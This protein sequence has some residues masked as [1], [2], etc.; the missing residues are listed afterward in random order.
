LVGRHRRPRGRPAPREIRTGPSLYD[1]ACPL[2]FGRV[3]LP[4]SRRSRL[5]ERIFVAC[6]T[7]I[8]KN[9]EQSARKLGPS[10]FGRPPVVRIAEKPAAIPMPSILD[11]S[12]HR[13][14]SFVADQTAVAHNDNGVLLA[15]PVQRDDLM[16]VRADDVER[17]K[18]RW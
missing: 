5:A 13:F 7:A 15:E 8:V 17:T 1:T 2:I 18:S 10:R 6:R 12:G 4:Y 14:P 16:A 9:I 11:L 3:V